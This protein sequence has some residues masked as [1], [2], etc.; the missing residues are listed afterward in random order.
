MPLAGPT[1]VTSSAAHAIVRTEAGMQR[2]A[3]PL[4]TWLLGQS[5][6]QSSRC[7]AKSTLGKKRSGVLLEE[8]NVYKHCGKEYGIPPA[9]VT[10]SGIQEKPPPIS[11]MVNSP[12]GVLSFHRS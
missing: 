9:S 11:Q 7:L 2:R 3:R 6:G 4:L 12:A 10:S 1:D 5:D 8:W